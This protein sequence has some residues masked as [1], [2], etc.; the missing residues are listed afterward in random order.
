MAYIEATAACAAIVE[1]WRLTALKA[2]FA[3]TVARPRILNV[4]EDISQMG[5]ILHVKINPTPSVGDVTAATGAYT[6]E[7]VTIT[8][9]DLTINKWKYVAHDI[10]DIAEIQ[11]DL[12]LYTNF[13]Q[14]FMPALGEQIES[15]IF[16]LHSSITSN[17]AVGDATDGTALGD[18]LLVPAQLTLD[19]LNIEA[20]NR[21]WFVP[22]VGVAQ[23][24]KQDKFVDA[25]K[26][27]EPKSIRTTGF[28]GLTVYGDPVYKSSKIATSGNIRKAIYC[29]RDGLMV[30]I[31]RNIKVEKFARTQF[32]TPFA[33]SVLY[34]VGVCRNNHSVVANVKKTLI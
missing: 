11:S 2:L 13:S 29:H 9:V 1:K 20:E 10:V 21:S 16:A 33:G 18:D 25:D 30:G 27:G 23:L 17:S 3:K 24:M 31:Q 5:D 14:A 26:T 4:T 8:N 28:K 15:D 22:P 7:Q 12:D 6:A 34:G 19:D 32:S